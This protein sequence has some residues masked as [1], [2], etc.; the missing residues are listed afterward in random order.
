MTVGL[1]F[2]ETS[3]IPRA[4]GT[5]SRNS[6]DRLSFIFENFILQVINFKFLFYGSTLELAD[7]CKKSH[8]KLHDT[9]SARQ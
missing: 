3:Q 8:E 9:N 7:Y 2:E 4:R 6:A 5:I 1:Q